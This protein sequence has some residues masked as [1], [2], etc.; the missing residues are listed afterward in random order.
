MIFCQ[1]LLS[2]ELDLIKPKANVFIAGKLLKP[3]VNNRNSI[4]PK[5]D[6]CS[7]QTSF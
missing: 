7:S 5:L 3:S 1:L 2:Y 4:L 6:T